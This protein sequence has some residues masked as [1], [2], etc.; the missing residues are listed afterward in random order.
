MWKRVATEAW[1]MARSNRR[2]TGSLVRTSTAPR[3]GEISITCGGLPQPTRYHALTDAS[4]ATS[5]ARRRTSAASQLSGVGL[6]PRA[7]VV[8]ERL[9]P[10]RVN[11][12]DRDGRDLVDCALYART[13]TLR[14]AK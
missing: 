11:E 12:E 2:R 8:G 9:Q 4:R 5:A 1:S 6:E 10:G 7:E 3:A 13:R 14:S